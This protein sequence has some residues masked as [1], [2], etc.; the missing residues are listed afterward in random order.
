MVRARG[1]LVI[2]L[3]VPLLLL[4]GSEGSAA[5]APTF[6]SLATGASAE[7]DL[8]TLVAPFAE[9]CARA[10][11]EIDRA[12]CR[13]ARA[14]L[15][16]RLPTKSFVSVVTDPEIVAVGEYDGR[17]QGA[18]LRLFGCLACRNR[19]T[20]GDAEQRMVTLKVPGGGATL[21]ESVE[22][23]SVIVTFPSASDA[24][25]WTKNVKPHLGAEFVF[26]PSG[27]A[28]TSHGHKGYAFTLV[29]ARV[30]DRCTGDVIL[31]E[32]KSAGPAAHADD[33]P[34]C[35][36]GATPVAAASDEGEPV[37]LPERL[38]P[39]AI[40]QAMVGMR[41]RRDACH[42]QFPMQGTATLA[43]EVS[44]KGIVVT[45]DVEGRLAGTALA[46]CLIDSARALQFPRFSVDRQRF[47]Y[48]LHFRR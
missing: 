9:D 14:Q 5:D 11:R 24:V 20:V 41:E 10:R 21:A 16:A 17:K 48:P 7:P 8:A 1:L 43:F 12:R 13:G 23:H 39:A 34:G 33:D 31:S 6:E 27:L 25:I 35:V 44:G 38:D 4:P 19:V 28:W 42:K 37:A 40:N 36:R 32:P 29:A 3:L 22:I 30:F 47:K 2:G 26:R 45:A 46:G 15:V 18:R